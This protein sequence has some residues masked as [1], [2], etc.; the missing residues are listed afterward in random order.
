MLDH[1][2]IRKIFSG[3][4]SKAR[5]DGPTHLLNPF[6]GPR[7]IIVMTYVNDAIY[8]T[9]LSKLC[10]TPLTEGLT[11]KNILAV[12][13]KIPASEQTLWRNGEEIEDDFPLWRCGIENND[14][15]R[16][17]YVEWSIHITGLDNKD[18][19]VVVL[20]TTT[21]GE[22]KAIAMKYHDY[23]D[24]FQSHELCLMHNKQKLDVNM[25]ILDYNIV[26]GDQMYVWPAHGLRD[27][28]LV[29]D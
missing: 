19:E 14:V 4:S 28:K 9:G 12:L 20:R 3:H 8:E 22:V 17:H 15:I 16:M 18:H 27:S 2:E 25:S 7:S 10:V 11:I 29:N 5:A 1:S 23:N 6:S 13:H 26:D 21:I 24:V